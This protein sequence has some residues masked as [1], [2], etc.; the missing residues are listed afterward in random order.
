[1]WGPVEF[2]D[3]LP[4]EAAFAHIADAAA[5]EIGIPLQ[6]PDEP[7]GTVAATGFPSSPAALANAAG[8]PLERA[9]GLQLLAATYRSSELGGEHLWER[10]LV[11]L[12]TLPAGDESART[13]R[14]RAALHLQRR[15]YALD[16]LRGVQSSEA[17]TLHA[18][19]QGNLLDAE[20]LA[21][22]V[23]DTAALRLFATVSDRQEADDWGRARNRS[24]TAQ[25]GEE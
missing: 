21:S 8:T 6:D 19:A 14:A 18:L 24:F 9:R 4:P 17:R 11:A 15:P 23:K 2:F 20:K 3:E 13:L 25:P 16:L 1:M 10:S 12:S 5:E 7:Q 22:E